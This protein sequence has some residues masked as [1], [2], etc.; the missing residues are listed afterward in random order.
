MDK[1]YSIDL[2]YLVVYQNT[3]NKLLFRLTVVKPSY[4]INEYTSMGWVVVDLQRYDTDR[5]NFVSLT[6]YRLLRKEYN[7]KY[8]DKREKKEKLIELLYNVFH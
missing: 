2:G 1:H 4:S 5:K 8:F 6:T 7:K 3:K